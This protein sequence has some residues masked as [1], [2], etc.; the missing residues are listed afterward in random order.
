MQEPPQ[1]PV[2]ATLKY[3]RLLAE[4]AALRFADP[5]QLKQLAAQVPLSLAAAH[6]HC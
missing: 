3:E 1:R 6:A 5:V 2:H 4:G